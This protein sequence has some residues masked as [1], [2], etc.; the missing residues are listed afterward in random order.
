MQM[1]FHGFC[2][3]LGLVFT[4]EH[5]DFARADVFDDFKLL[6]Q[7][8]Q[9]VHLHAVAC[10]LN[11]DGRFGHVNRVGMEMVA[12][13]K[14][15][16]TLFGGATNLDQGEFLF[17]RVRAGMVLCMH[18]VNQL[19]ELL[20]DLHQDVG[21]TAGN[22]VHAAKAWIKRRRDDQGIDIVATT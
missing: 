20:D 16:G 15:F 7:A 19:F 18:H 3:R 17:N 2:K 11:N 10:N 1:P 5:D 8:P 12:K 14:D 6:E 21:I 4:A 9:G 22:N 13:L